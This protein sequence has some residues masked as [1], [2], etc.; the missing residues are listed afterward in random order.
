MEGRKLQVTVLAVASLGLSGC[1]LLWLGAGAAGGYALSKD[2]VRNQFDLPKE[3]VYQHS[4]AV[5]KDTGLVTLEDPTHG[6]IQVKVESANVTITVRQI[7]QHAVELKV[8]ARNQFLMPKI[9]VAQ[10]IYNKIVARL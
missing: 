10:A 9:D 3:T 2:S 8:Q 1:P 5:A 6:K 4:L 7:T